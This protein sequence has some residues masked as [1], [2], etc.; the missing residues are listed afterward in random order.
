MFGNFSKV[1]TAAVRDP[2]CY[3][4]LEVATTRISDGFMQPD[5]HRLRGM[6]V[7]ADSSSEIRPENAAKSGVTVFSTWNPA[8]PGN[9]LTSACMQ[10]QQPGWSRS[11]TSRTCWMPRYPR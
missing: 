9:M 6:F 8:R 1:L 5:V 7:Q 10:L 2:C 11:P 3:T 4:S